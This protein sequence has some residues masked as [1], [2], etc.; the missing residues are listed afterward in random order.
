[1]M[2]S[3]STGAVACSW[4]RYKVIREPLC[5]RIKKKINVKL[6]RNLKPLHVFFYFFLYILGVFQS[7]PKAQALYSCLGTRI[8]LKGG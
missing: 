2:S 4:W 1:M 5:L 7:F 3:V 6:K 8:I